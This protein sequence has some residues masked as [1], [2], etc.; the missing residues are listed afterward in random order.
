M[1]S[2]PGPSALEIGIICDCSHQPVV[3]ATARGRRIRAG[4]L[5]SRPDGAPQYPDH[6]SAL[7]E[8]YLAG[9][10]FVSDPPDEVGA[11]GTEGLVEAM[12]YSLLAGGKRVRPVLAMATLEALGPA[13]GTPAVGGRA[14]S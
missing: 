3:A 8:E 7:V 12:R 10:Y 2:R 6:L 13:R 5:G 4:P 11:E 9:L 1:G 14:S